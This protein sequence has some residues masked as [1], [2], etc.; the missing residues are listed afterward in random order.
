MLRHQRPQI[1]AMAPLAR[2]AAAARNKVRNANEAPA[3]PL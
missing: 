2:A 3:S 1:A